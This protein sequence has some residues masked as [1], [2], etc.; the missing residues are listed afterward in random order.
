[1]EKE[2]LSE[3]SPI[4]GRRTNQ[5]FLKPFDYRQS[6]LFVPRYTPEEKAVVYGVT[7][8]VAKYLSLF[9]D[10][11]SLDENLINH[12]FRTSGYLYEEP[13]NLL[14]QEFRNISAYNSVIEV[15]SNGAN[16][17]NEIADKAHIS[18]AALTYI[19][20]SL[21][22][23]GIISK[24]TPLTEEKNKKKTKYEI[25]DEMYRFWY[26]FVPR[27]KAAI[28]MNRGEKYYYSTVKPRLHEYMGGIFERICRQYTLS[29]GLE[30]ALACFVTQ[31]GTWWGATAK[32][33]QTDIDVVGIDPAERKA[34]L[35]ECKFKNEPMDKSV[36]D[37]LLSRKGLLASRYDEVQ[38]LLFSLSGFSPWFNDLH[39]ARVRLIPLAEM[40]A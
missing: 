17:V 13:S 29:Q 14:T 19:L 27:A 40:Y 25:T 32:G 33:E 3:K 9:D 1:M 12:F 20:N 8:G 6:A 10:S 24:I 30:G 22:T 16:K 5:I 37:A 36:Y 23:V 28:E 11:K 18:T 38:F 2:I 31:V 34:V 21:I 7:G 15:C 4:F 26:T 35:G 39:D